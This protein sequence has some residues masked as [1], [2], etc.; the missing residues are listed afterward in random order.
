[1][2]LVDR[3]T[4]LNRRAGAQYLEQLESRLLTTVETHLL[5]S[6]N[7]S[8]T[9]H[10]LVVNESIDLVVLCAHGHTGESKWPYGS[11]TL[12]FIAYG[13]TPL[14]IVQDF[15]GREAAGMWAEG[16]ASEMKGH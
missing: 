16:A 11:I 2:T 5:V 9:L 12:N 4:E 7:A 6:D 13:T 15:P 10:K 8:A 1:M 14:L 3:L